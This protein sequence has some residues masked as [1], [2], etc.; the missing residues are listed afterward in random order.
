MQMGSWRRF[1]A[2]AAVAIS[3]AAPAR[4]QLVIPMPRAT[5]TTPR[6]AEASAVPSVLRVVHG[7]VEPRFDPWGPL[8]REAATRFGI[9]DIWIR[10]VM[11]MESGG[12]P[13][14]LSWA[15]AMGLMQVI[16]STYAKLR[17]QHGLGPNPWEPRDN[18][19]AGAAYIREMYDLYG[20]PAFLA[21]YNAG[22]GRVEAVINRSSV[23]PAETVN[24]LNVL[25]PRLQ[26][27]TVAEGP[28]SVFLRPGA[29]AASAPALDPVVIRISARP[30]GTPQS[31]QA[32]VADAMGLVP[33]GMLNG[34]QVIRM[35]S[36]GD[37]PAA[38]VALPPALVASL[39]RGAARR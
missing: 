18:I 35:P 21:A 25:A 23:L 11:R 13:L 20:F 27:T 37:A 2:V 6:P 1:G 19:L 39:L 7:N 10:E 36:A 16:P 14:A 4:A 28:L 8:I 34:P 32:P 26:G 24:Y 5:D 22:P 29:T 12:N 33:R 15:G 9:P 17:W 3:L 30:T 38:P 31:A